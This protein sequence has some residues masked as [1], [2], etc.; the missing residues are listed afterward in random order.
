MKRGPASHEL[1]L[2][3]F[4]LAKGAKDLP[5]RGQYAWPY[6]VS[7]CF[8]STPR[9]VGFAEGEGQ[10]AGGGVFTAIEALRPQWREHFAAA[11][12]EWL[13]P[14]IE[15]LAAGQT[16]KADDLMAL[17]TRTLGRAPE[18]FVYRGA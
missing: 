12:G 5:Q 15:Q 14:F 18:S 11:N 1:M 16:L 9:P 13:I 17:A 3:Y 4:V 10:A 8:E 6:E 2:R 7:L